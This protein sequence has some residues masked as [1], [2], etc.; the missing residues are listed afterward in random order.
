VVLRIGE[1]CR[2]E[3]TYVLTFDFRVR[4]VTPPL[5]LQRGVCVLGCVEISCVR[6]HYMCSHHILVEEH[7]ATYELHVQPLDD[8]RRAWRR[9]HLGGLCGALLLGAG[10]LLLPLRPTGSLTKHGLIPEELSD[11]PPTST[12]EKA[13]VII[14][15]HGEKP[16]EG[17][18]L[19]ELGKRRA[20]YIARC[21]SQEQPTVALPA[22]KPSYVMASHGKDDHSHRPIDTV[23]PLAAALGLK[24][25]EGTYFKD[26]K[27]FAQHIQSVLQPKSTLVVAWHHGEIAELVKELLGQEQWRLGDLAWPDKWPKH[28]G[29]GEYAEPTFQHGGE[30][31]D[32]V[33]RVTLIR[34]APPNATKGE[35]A[36]EATEV[37]DRKRNQIER[38]GWRA[39]S[40]TASL[41]GFRGL[42]NDPCKEGL[43]PV[44]TGFQ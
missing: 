22:G 23:A 37:L 28:C 13:H 19:S 27:G 24:L 1:I 32:L 14:I 15:R 12:Q 21:M 4:V 9:Q 43:T 26:S 41:Q 16:D 5:H 30:C 40:L 18:G 8:R 20:Q 25:D 7:T 39:V 2:C 6:A 35:S 11:P 29:S 38:F 31:Y 17:D 42:A 3:F 44:G 33:W 36:K 10:L 34:H